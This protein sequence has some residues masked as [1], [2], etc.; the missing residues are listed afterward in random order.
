MHSHTQAA[1]R[2]AAG[3][4]AG[5]TARASKESARASKAVSEVVT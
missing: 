4:H 5:E 1:A 3:P 2:L